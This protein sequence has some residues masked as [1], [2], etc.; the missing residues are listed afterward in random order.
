MAVMESVSVCRGTWM[1]SQNIPSYQQTDLLTVYVIAK[2][3]AGPNDLVLIDLYED[4]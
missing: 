2:C 3:L 4:P 1:C